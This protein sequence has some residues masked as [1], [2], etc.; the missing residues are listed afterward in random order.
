MQSPRDVPASSPATPAERSS[1]EPASAQED[2]SNN[3]RSMTPDAQK[4][5]PEDEDAQSSTSP[6]PRVVVLTDDRDQ[7]KTLQQALTQNPD[8][9]FEVIW[10]R[11][12]S[13]ALEQV[14]QGS[15]TAIIADLFLPDSSGIST[16]DILFAAAPH[17]PILTIGARKN[18]AVA[19]A[20]VHRGAE[21]YLSKGH[22]DSGL[23]PE[24]LRRIVERRAIDE[25]SFTEKSRAEIALNSIGDAVL[26]TD[27]SGKIDYL[28]I[29]GESITGWSREEARGRPIDDVF[30][31]INSQTREPQIGLTDMVIKSDEPRGLK[32]DTVL[33][34]RDR[35]EVP[36]EDSA[37]PIH[38][39]NG[40]ATGVVIVFHDVSEAKAMATKMAHLA[41]HDFLTNLPNRALLNDRITHAISLAK[42]RNAQLAVLFIDLDNF[43][44]INDSL[45]HAG[46]DK[47]LKSVA[48]RL[49]SC[50]RGSDTVSRQGGDEF[51]ALLTE[52]HKEVDGAVIAEKILFSLKA[53]HVIGD[54][55]VNVMASI[56]ISVYPID[57]EDAET[58]I[59][60]ADT[61]MYYAKKKGRNNFKFFRSEMNV[62]AIERQAIEMGLRRALEKQEFFLQYQP[63]INLSTGTITGAEALLRWNHAEW[64]ILS[65]ERFISIAED[66]GLIVSIG[67]FVIRQACMA[68]KEWA[69]TKS[70]PISISVNVSALELRQRDFVKSIRAVIEEIGLDS[71][72]LELEITE[73][74][75]MRDAESSVAILRELK[76]MGVSLAIDDFGTGYSSLSY[77]TKFPIDVLKIDQSFVRD[78]QSDVQARI[79]ANAIVELGN[80]LNLRVVA[81]GVEDS[82]QLSFLQERNCEEGQGYLFSRP[83]V[84]DRFSSLLT[85]G[86]P[87]AMEAIWAK[88]LPAATEE[89]R[90]TRSNGR[91]SS[92][93]SRV[94]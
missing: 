16:F 77:L 19:I 54:R 87:S 49:R 80:S 35:S 64:G 10:L 68:A 62:R 14:R 2:H 38:D 39:W 20:A 76:A 26:C 44:Y 83:I 81:E 43:K 69:E 22:F 31:L 28:N 21:A 90:P 1:D 61:A 71:R 40:K 67:R 51:I 60:R 17:V 5:R 88:P 74:V 72:L 4:G 89:F 94:T 33:I 47:L 29:A 52:G 9:S 32:A 15:V 24:T 73:S 56:G 93:R 48:T 65:P 41:Q 23:V 75:L 57:G 45:G 27:M 46:G 50:V 30:Q 85:T 58:L 91:D 79:V 12:L 78:I 84:A 3:P 42:R 34:R 6:T 11:L 59:K 18:I 8:C 7:A 36:I 82:A 63:K 25:A 92:G 13:S 66:C 55:H 86:L 53:P 70:S 37:S